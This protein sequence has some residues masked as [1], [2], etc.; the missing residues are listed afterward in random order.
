MTIL[1]TPMSPVTDFY[2]VKAANNMT[3]T[4]DEY[5]LFLF[6]LFSR[7]RSTCVTEANVCSFGGIFYFLFSFLFKFEKSF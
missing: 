2:T 1:N 4:Q 6:V 7:K 5:S 3:D